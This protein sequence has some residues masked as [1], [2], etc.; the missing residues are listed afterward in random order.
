MSQFYCLGLI[1]ERGGLRGVVDR[2]DCGRRPRKP[3]GGR[4]GWLRGRN[5]DPAF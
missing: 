3:D 1:E 2:C 4:R 5:S